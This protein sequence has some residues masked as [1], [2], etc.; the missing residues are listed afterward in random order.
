VRILGDTKENAGVPCEYA[1]VLHM[2]YHNIDSS[3]IY[4]VSNN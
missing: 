2:S 4:Q 1:P 3:Y